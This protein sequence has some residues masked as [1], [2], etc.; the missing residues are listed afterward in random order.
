MLTLRV[1]AAVLG[2]LAI[3]LAVSAITASASA[4]P[5]P[6]WRHRANSKE[7]EGAKIEPKAPENLKGE[8]GEQRLLGKIATTEIEITSPGTQKVPFS[9]AP[10]EAK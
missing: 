2:L 1:R 3:A 4:E 6:F 7:G 9:T 8:G 5:G 10:N